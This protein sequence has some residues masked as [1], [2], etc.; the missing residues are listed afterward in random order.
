MERSETRKIIQILVATYPNFKPA[1]LTDTVDAWQFF[2][3]DYKYNDIAVA[4][5]TYVST[6]GSGFAPSAAE[7]IAMIHKPAQ[8]AQLTE[9]EAW[10]LV[11]KAAENGSYHA[12]EEFDKLPPMVQRAV[13]SANMIRN[14]AREDYKVLDS[15]IASNFQRSYRAIA[16]SEDFKGRLPIEARTRYEALC[17]KG[18]GLIGNGEGF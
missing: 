10:A 11:R 7:L 15:V 9:Q 1:D 12:E 14:W 6:S 8:A 18:V 2:L 13:G 16:D 17:E 3:A 4:L 5:K